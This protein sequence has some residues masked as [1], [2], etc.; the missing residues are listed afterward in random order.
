MFCLFNFCVLL[1]AIDCTLKIFSLNQQVILRY[2]LN[3][4]RCKHS[5]IWE[6]SG[7]CGIET[8]TLALSVVEE[9]TMLDS[10]WCQREGEITHLLPNNTGFQTVWV[11]HISWCSFKS[12]SWEK[13]C[14]QVTMT[15][16]G[17][18]WL[19]RQLKGDKHILNL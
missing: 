8:Q 1:L 10:R 5:D 18:P 16:S 2:K 11:F 3:F 12:A 6:C 15:C 4:A 7:N 17:E 13:N 9:E 19:W 14:E